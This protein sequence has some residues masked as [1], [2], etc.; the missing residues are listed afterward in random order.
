MRKRALARSVGRMNGHRSFWDRLFRRKPERRGDI[1][2]DTMDFRDRGED[3][4]KAL[5]F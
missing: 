1:S 4:W 2:A 3:V 5:R